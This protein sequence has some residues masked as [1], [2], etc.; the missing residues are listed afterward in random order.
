MRR[1]TDVALVLSAAS[2]KMLL[3]MLLA[4]I[5]ALRITIV[6]LPFRALLNDMAR[7]CQQHDVPYSILTADSCNKDCQ[8]VLAIAEHALPLAFST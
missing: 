2:G 7:R 8:L 1:N 3:L 5:E 6:I 4:R